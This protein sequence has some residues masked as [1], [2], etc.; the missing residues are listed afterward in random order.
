M[1]GVPKNSSSIPIYKKIE[2]ELRVMLDL[3]DHPPHSQFLT[4]VELCKRFNVN[5]ITARKAV[6]RLVEQGRLYKVHRSGTF[7]SPPPRN[8]LVLLI[9]TDPQE[10]KIG[11]LTPVAAKYP[12]LQ[13]QELYIDDLRPHVSDIKHVYPKLIGALFVRDLPNCRDVME[14][15]KNQG[16]AVCF[17]GSDVHA[18]YLENTHSVLCRESDLIGMALEHL[19]DRGCSR[20][21][22]IGTTEWAAF[23]AREK[24]IREWGKANG[25]PI[26]EANIMSTH[27]SDL[28]NPLICHEKIKDHLLNPDFDADGVF[29]ANDEVAANFVQVALAVGIKIPKQLK[30]I[31]TDDNDRISVRI[32]PQISAVRLPIDLDIQTGLKLLSTESL[33]PGVCEKKF[34]DL[35]LVPRQST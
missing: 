12:D 7:V 3:G 1:T 16:V 23:A 33:P 28:M 27:F 22:S 19:R 10:S 2:R 29:C 8:R 26:K 21:G 24:A 25:M 9:T 31:T 14:E 5:P 35:H 34:T 30:V 6:G 17:C 32:F 11:C 15:L 18:P 4:E 13:W 20:I